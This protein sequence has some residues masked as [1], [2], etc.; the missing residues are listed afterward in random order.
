MAEERQATPVS[1]ETLE[2]TT[3]FVE[4]EPTSCSCGASGC[5]EVPPAGLP[6]SHGTFT[7]IFKH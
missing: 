3:R 7:E 5:G 4:C 2:Y 1:N 6:W